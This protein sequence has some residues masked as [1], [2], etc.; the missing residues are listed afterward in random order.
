M[1]N[2]F[3]KVVDLLHLAKQSGIRVVLN[4]D[5]LQLTYVQKKAIDKELLEEIKENKQL[6]VDYLA[7]KNGKS[8]RV[9]KDHQLIDGSARSLLNH[10]KQRMTAQFKKIIVD[11]YTLYLQQ[12]LPDFHQFRFQ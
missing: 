10:N 4:D 3:L 11:A 5:Q 12:L 2:N 7:N 9:E 8:I 6:I 1:R